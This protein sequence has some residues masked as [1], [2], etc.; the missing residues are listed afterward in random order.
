MGLE[1]SEMSKR[2][3]MVEIWMAGRDESTNWGLETIKICRVRK[4]SDHCDREER[5]DEEGSNWCA[6]EAT[7]EAGQE[8]RDSERRRAMERGQR[9]RAGRGV[10]VQIDCSQS[11]KTEA[12][13]EGAYGTRERECDRRWS[14]FPATALICSS[15]NNHRRGTKIISPIALSRVRRTRRA[16]KLGG[17]PQL[18]L[19]SG[20]KGLS[21]S[22]Q[23]Y[24]A[25]LT[26][27]DVRT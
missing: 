19:H 12:G 5:I 9:G 10:L 20:L 21:R 6:A 17:R 27:F 18:K 15:V 16:G 11:V 25:D 2:V 4:Y 14:I 24:P 7:V 22:T 3:E 13:R 8:K 1:T 26:F 23:G